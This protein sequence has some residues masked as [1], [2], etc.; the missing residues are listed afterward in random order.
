M[1]HNAQYSHGYYRRS[2]DL[3]EN[4]YVVFLLLQFLAEV[5]L[6]RLQLHHP[7]PQLIGLLPAGRQPMGRQRSVS[8]WGSTF[9]LSFTGDFL[10]NHMCLC[11]VDHFNNEIELSMCVPN[12]TLFP[13]KC[14]TFDQSPGAF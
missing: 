1:D 2:L 6:L 9:G 4:T 13:E 5:K 8:A 11:T 12:D 10:S 14:I 3:S 7:L